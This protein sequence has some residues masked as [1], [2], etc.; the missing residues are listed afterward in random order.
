MK[1]IITLVC[2][3]L[4]CVSV[5]GTAAA[6]V[7]TAS[8]EQKGAPAVVEIMDEAGNSAIAALSG[9]LPEDLVLVSGD[10][11][12]I[13]AVADA[14][15]S[16][17]IPDASQQALLEVY[18]GLRDGSIAVPFAELDAEHADALVVRD[19]FDISWTG[20]EGSDFE[21]LLDAE[22]VFLEM[23]FALE[24][25]ADAKVYVMVYKNNAWQQIDQVTNNGDGTI[26]CVFDH[27]CPVAVVVENNEAVEA[28]SLSAER[29][30]G[31]NPSQDTEAEE[32][33]EGNLLLWVGILAAS[34]LGLTV[35]LAGKK[36][37]QK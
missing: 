20:S 29:A 24:I 19:L 2:A 22:D 12:V 32:T 28:A 18:N 17:R 35:L 8:V 10:C 26:T 1:K 37:K 25:E 14:E 15:S 30:Q 6:E 11:L 21:K 33:S 13:T 34:V 31:A 9:N 27:L 3:L 4:V 16:D 7:F 36:R 5:T 23:T